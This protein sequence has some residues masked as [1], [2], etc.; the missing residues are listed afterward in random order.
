MFQQS[1]EGLGSTGF[2]YTVSLIFTGITRNYSSI[3]WD[4]KQLN[5]PCIQACNMSYFQ[6]EY[7]Q[8]YTMS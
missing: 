3:A 2:L 5:M 1:L 7:M 8:L 6:V 4:E